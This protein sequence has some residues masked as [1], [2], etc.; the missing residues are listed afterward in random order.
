LWW[1]PTGPLT[2]L[3]LHAA[4]LYNQD[5]VSDYVISS[6][7]PTLNALLTPIPHMA[8]DFKVLVAIQ[9]EAPGLATLTCAHS[10]LLEIE[11]VFQHDTLF[12]LG[13]GGVPASV[14]NVLSLLSDVSIAHFACHGQQ[15]ISDPL[16]S[17]LILESGN[18]LEISRFMEKRLPKASLVFLSAC[19]T[20]MGDEN[21]PDEAMH[22]AASML[23]IGFHG[24]VATMWL[25]HIFVYVT[26]VLIR[27]RS[28]AD[29]DGPNIT[30][31]FYR[32]LSRTQ[33]QDGIH[34]PDATQAA[35][36]LHLAVRQLREEGCSFRRWVPF[37]HIGQ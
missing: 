21:L 33:E 1:C 25:V 13:V 18:K 34:V 36:A 30:K 24:A 14:H 32:Y 27:H 2:F 28:M 29:E 17:G 6:Y 37:I 8:P 9:P 31:T 22:L 16:K 7:T 23:F 11:K 35:R 19:E 5:I 26:R 3:P 15:D 4:G 20:A 10:E 12:K